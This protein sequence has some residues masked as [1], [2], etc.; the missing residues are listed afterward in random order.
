MDLDQYITI[1]EAAEL[2][3]VSRW[4]LYQAIR[5]ERLQ[6]IKVLGHVAVARPDVLAYKERT[7]EVGKQGGRPR[8]PKRPPGRPRKQKTV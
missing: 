1:K 6:S 5:D 8:K 2:I 3:G 4:A 7:A